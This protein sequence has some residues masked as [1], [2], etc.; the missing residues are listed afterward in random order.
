[1]QHPSSTPQDLAL[2]RDLLA[3]EIAELQ[4]RLDRIPPFA[5]QWGAVFEHKRRALCLALDF[6]VSL[7][8]SSRPGQ[9]G[10]SAASR[11]FHA[12]GQQLPRALI[13]QGFASA[14]IEVPAEYVGQLDVGADLQQL[15]GAKVAP[16]D[17][18]GETSPLGVDRN[19]GTAH[20][21]PQDRR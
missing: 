17:S 4:V 12:H 16:V 3:V 18:Q 21:P 10:L 8:A 15:E 1:M 6:A 19:D 20:T 14:G 11:D 5:Q 9:G 7:L 2:L 13:L